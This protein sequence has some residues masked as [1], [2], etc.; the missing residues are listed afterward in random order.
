MAI[1]H[2]QQVPYEFAAYASKP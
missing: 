1:S 2:L